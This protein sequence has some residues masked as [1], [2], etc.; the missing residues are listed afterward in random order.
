MQ[1][2]VFIAGFIA[3]FLKGFIFTY[4]WKWFVIPVFA[5]DPI[6]I[7]LA[8][9]LSII[10]SFLTVNMNDITELSS[11]EQLVKIIY[12]YVYPIIVFGVAFVVQAF[13]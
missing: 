4:L 7:P 13:I 9:G 8:I 3:L 12:M 5:V 10:A 11:E 1:L 2:L 6:S